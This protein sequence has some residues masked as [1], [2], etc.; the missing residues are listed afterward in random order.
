M[1]L[2]YY[3]GNKP[4][5]LATFM[6]K[7]TC[8]GLWRLLLWQKVQQTVSCPPAYSSMARLAMGEKCGALA[9]PPIL[10]NG[11][12]LQDQSAQMSQQRQICICFPGLKRS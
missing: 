2:I 10:H 9:T 6:Y 3:Q 4:L 7:S 5:E 1:P 12:G 8:S 11:P